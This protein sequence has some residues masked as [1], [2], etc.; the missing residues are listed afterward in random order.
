[1]RLH[2]HALLSLLLTALLSACTSWEVTK[3]EVV[4]PYNRLVHFDYPAAFRGADVEAVVACYGPDLE[5]WGRADAES[6]LSGFDR[7]DRARCVIHDARA[8]DDDGIL[9]ADCVLRIDGVVDGVPRTFEQ[10]RVVRGALVD[11]AWKIVGVDAGRTMDVGGRPRFREEAAERGLVAMNRSRGIPALDGSLVPDLS[12]SGLALGDVDVDGLDDVLLVSGDRLRLFHNLGGEFDEITE[13]AGLETPATGECRCAYF[14]DVDGDG[15]PDLFVGLVGAQDVLFENLGDGRFRELA[16]EQSGIETA[17]YTTG[18]CLADFD[19]DGDLDLFVISGN[20][21]RHTTHN[22]PRDATNGNPNLY[23]ENDGHGR[24]T[25]ATEAAGLQDTRWALACATSDYDR[26]GD[27]D[28]FVANDVGLDLLYRNRGDGTFENVAEESGL[29]F[30]GSSMSAA[31]GDVNGDGWPDLYAT[32]MASNS[33]WL[34]NQPGFPLPT[35][36]I[37][38][39]LFRPFVIEGMW[40][41]FH[42]NRLYLN[43]GDGSFAEVS[44]P[45]R[46]Y[47]CGWALSGVFLDY[48]NDTHLD[49]YVANGFWTGEKDYDC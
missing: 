46:S 47:W 2:A 48:D 5:G 40:E 6:V 11:G 30:Y 38:T 1:M 20:E 36:W 34:L 32:G 31:F 17:G 35:P 41:M 3:Q 14:G 33:R 9:E 10:E 27:V 28:L 37:V 39:T 45:T 44:I 16:P 49:V 13:A 26:D 29:G 21:V 25:E 15:D 8:P 22:D 42:G 18:A 43:Q 4:T 12:S 24:F 23:F 19:R 7:V